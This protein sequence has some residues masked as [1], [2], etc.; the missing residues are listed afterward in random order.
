MPLAEANLVNMLDFIYI[1]HGIYYN[2]IH[3]KNFKLHKCKNEGNHAPA[4][5]VLWPPL[6]GDPILVIPPES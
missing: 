6:V 1:E 5:L 3:Q 2:C 4:P